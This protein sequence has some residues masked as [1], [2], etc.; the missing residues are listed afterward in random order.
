MRLFKADPMV[1]TPRHRDDTSCMPGPARLKPLELWKIVGCLFV[2]AWPY[3]SPFSRAADELSWTSHVIFEAAVFTRQN[4]PIPY[5]V[6]SLTTTSD[7]AVWV[8]MLLT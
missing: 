4:S 5:G 6:W 2:V 8:A 1:K 3:G 7:G